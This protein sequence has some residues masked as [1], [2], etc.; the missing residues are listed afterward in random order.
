M[1]PNNSVR[2]V[3]ADITEALIYLYLMPARFNFLRYTVKCRQQSLR[4]SVMSH[5][6]QDLID[7]FQQTFYYQYQTRL[8]KG[9]G[10]PVYLPADEN[11]PDHRIEFAHGFFASGLHEISHWLVAGPKRRLLED[12]GYW[13]LPDGRDAA[14]QA[15]FEDVEVKPQA[16]EWSLS[17]AAGFEFNVSCDNLDGVE[18][19]RFAFQHRVHQQ[20]EHYLTHGYP[21][22]VKALMAALAE[23]YQQQIPNRIEDFNYQKTI[24]GAAA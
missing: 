23:F 13:Y 8:V 2:L 4:P 14:K 22:R 1:L 17:L 5:H 18:P 9:A 24:K 20:V 6:Y 21:K 7:I 19:D 11:N 15:V 3:S 10:E 12:F 16:I